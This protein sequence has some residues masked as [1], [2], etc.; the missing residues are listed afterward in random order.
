[1]TPNDVVTQNDLH[2]IFFVNY[3][4]LVIINNE[5]RDWSLIYNDL[6]WL[7]KF[8]TR[9]PIRKTCQEVYKSPYGCQVVV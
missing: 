2:L 5:S 9:V 4:F 8:S 7:N 1:M 6:M 3:A